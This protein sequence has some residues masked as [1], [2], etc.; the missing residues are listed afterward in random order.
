[1]EKYSFQELLKEALEKRIEKYREL[2]TEFGDKL[3][4]AG[5]A[6]LAQMSE[7]LLQKEIDDE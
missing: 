1:M 6:I 5:D 3:A 7:E 2:H 4:S